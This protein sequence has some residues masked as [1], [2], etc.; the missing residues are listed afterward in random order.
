MRTMTQDPEDRFQEWSR[1]I[2]GQPEALMQGYASEELR[3][4]AIRSFTARHHENEINLWLAA[5]RR[6]R[7]RDEPM[8]SGSNCLPWLDERSS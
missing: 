6:L 8:P 5:P 4:N 7:T 1:P 2:P 3:D